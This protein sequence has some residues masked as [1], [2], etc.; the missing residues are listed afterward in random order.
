MFLTSKDKF[1]IYPSNL[2]Q[3]L[4]FGFGTKQLGD[5]RDKK[6]FLEYFKDQVLVTPK[7]THSINIIQYKSGDDLSPNNCDGVVTKEKNITLSVITADCLPIIYY[8]QKAEIIGISHQG[9]KGSLNRLPALI[10][11]KMKDL[12]SD[13]ENIH[14][15]FGP[16]INDCCYDI[17][18]ERLDLFQKEFNSDF[19]YRKDGEK[20]FLNLYKVNYLSLQNIDYFPFCTSFDTL[21]FY[22]YKRD[23]K[24]L[25][26][27]ISFIRLR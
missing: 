22:S 10:I 11:K 15:V 1:Y 3:N 25:G 21:R 27:M 5:G 16:A 26:E 19:I 17:Y 7:Q 24:L 8:D 9:W 4:F 12:G 2:P 14:C 13:I 18:G 20:Y 23:K 6:L